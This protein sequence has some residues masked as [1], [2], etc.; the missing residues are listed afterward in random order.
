MLGDDGERCHDGTS[1][2]GLPDLS[3]TECRLLA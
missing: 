1:G 2:F 3:L